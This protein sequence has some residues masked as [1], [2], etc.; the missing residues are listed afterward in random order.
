MLFPSQDVP[1]SPLNPTHLSSS[2]TLPEFLR[3]NRAHAHVHTRTKPVLERYRATTIPFG[4]HTLSPALASIRVT[5]QYFSPVRALYRTTRSP[6]MVPRRSNFPPRARMSQ[7]PV[8]LRRPFGHSK[9]SEKVSP[10]EHVLRPMPVPTATPSLTTNRHYLV[11][12][13]EGTTKST[14]QLFFIPR[15]GLNCVRRSRLAAHT[16]N[17]GISPVC[18]FKLRFLVIRCHPSH[19][20][21]TPAL[22]PFLT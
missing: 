20:F 9:S 13:A 12:P 22:H 10:L 15:S 14:P 5:S 8:H 4:N 6:R 16:T 7:Y 11:R 3:G 21:P 17:I 18:G 1:S 19:H 2:T